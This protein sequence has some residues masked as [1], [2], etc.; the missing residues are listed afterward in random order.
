[1][2]RGEVPEEVAGD[3]MGHK[4]TSQHEAIPQL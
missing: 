2:N 1:M 3:L 4:I